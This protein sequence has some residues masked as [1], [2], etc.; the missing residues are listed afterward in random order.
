[1]EA[2]L[3]GRQAAELGLDILLERFPLEWEIQACFWAKK[4]RER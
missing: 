4:T 2:I 3:D 1:V